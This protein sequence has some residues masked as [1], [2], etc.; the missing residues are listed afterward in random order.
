MLLRP[1][2]EHC[3]QLWVP[4]QM[5]GMNLCEILQGR[6]TRTAKALQGKTCEERLKV[7]GP[8]AEE[9]Q[10]RPRGGPWLP[11]EGSGGAGAGLCSLGPVTEPE[12]MAWS[13]FRGGSGQLFRNYL[14]PERVLRR[15]NRLSRDVAISLSLLQLKQCLQKA[16]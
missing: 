5:K 13:C 12:K 6:A 15:W 10:G 16:V 7:L 8:R 4:Q 1:C 2:I 9:M 11:D 3:V 14:F